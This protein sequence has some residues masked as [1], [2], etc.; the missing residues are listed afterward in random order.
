[1]QYKKNY[2]TEVI[3]RIDFDKPVDSSKKLADDFFNSIESVFPKHAILHGVE[4]RGEII[5]KKDGSNTVSQS[6]Q[7]VTNYR[8]WD[9]NKSKSLVLEP[10]KDINLVVKDYINSTELK[11]IINLVVDSM[12][13]VYGDIKIKRTGLRYINDIRIQEGNPFDWSP[14]INR[15]LISNM[16][17]LGED[18]K[19]SRSMGIIEL[20][21]ED[22]KVLFQFG[23]YNPEYPNSIA[24]KVFVLDYDCYTTDDLNASEIK[25]RINILQKDEE[26]LFERSIEDGLRQI[27]GVVTDDRRSSG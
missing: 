26:K 2:L 7:K 27:M 22:H 24:K 6:Q 9:E 20:I 21:R 8:F 4:L 12:I 18:D 1:M 25:D 17:F 15:Y 16:N 13:K 19:L 10:L 11:N 3:F 5:S 14:F 23:M